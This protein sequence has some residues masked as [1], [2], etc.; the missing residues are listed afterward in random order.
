MTDVP[1]RAMSSGQ[2]GERDPWERNS[3]WKNRG[4]SSGG[5]TTVGALSQWQ[6]VVIKCTESVDKTLSSAVTKAPESCMGSITT[7]YSRE[8]LE[9]MEPV[10]TSSIGIPPGNKVQKTLGEKTG[11]FRLSRTQMLKRKIEREERQEE[12]VE[13]KTASIGVQTQVSLPERMIGIWTC[14][15]PV[16]DTVVDAPSIKE[17]DSPTINRP[18][19]TATLKS[20]PPGLELVRSTSTSDETDESTEGPTR[21]D[22]HE[23]V[24]DRSTAPT[25]GVK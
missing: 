2:T 9:I 6:P 5:A 22:T 4:T 7:F 14:R 18:V 24:H 12:Q 10:E 1:D 16:A 25:D 15:C 11:P 3:P 19:D 20:P 17:I 13:K 21:A 23:S 8:P